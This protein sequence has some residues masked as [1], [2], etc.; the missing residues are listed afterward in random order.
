MS[1]ERK[2]VRLS[3][4]QKVDQLLTIEP[5]FPQQGHQSAFWQVTIVSRHHRAAARCRVVEDEMA[6]RS[7]I[8]SESILLQK[9]DDFGGLTAGSLGIP[10]PYTKH[11]TYKTSSKDRLKWK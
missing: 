1:I 3:A 2:P 8:Q 10:N 7:V 11:K 9:T 6:A 5:S 4:G